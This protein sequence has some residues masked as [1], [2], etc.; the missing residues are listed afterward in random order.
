MIKKTSQS[1]R[2]E[3]GQAIL[4]HVTQEEKEDRVSLYSK[5]HS[6]KEGNGVHITLPMV[7]EFR[8]LLNAFA[9]DK[10][11]S[12]LW[13]KKQDPSLPTLNGSEEPFSEVEGPSG[14]VVIDMGEGDFNTLITSG[15]I[16]IEDAERESFARGST[17]FERRAVAYIKLVMKI[18][19]ERK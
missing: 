11:P 5:A 16:L 18:L 15:S 2:Y 6:F 19:G 1:T 10:D 4:V 9:A 8:E 14:D 12:A 17:A 13:A 7:R 3:N